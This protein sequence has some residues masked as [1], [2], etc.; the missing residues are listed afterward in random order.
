MA[1]DKFEKAG[2]RF[3]TEELDMAA[4]LEITI[5]DALLDL[6]GGRAEVQNRAAEWLT[7]SLFTRDKISSGKAARL[8][9]ISRIEFL[10]L[11]REHGIAYADYADEEINAEIA[12][13][14]AL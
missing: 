6:G 7:L 5:P 3:D 9:G 12:A 13:A 10:R 2:M 8:L 1:C 11:L 4:T 14:K